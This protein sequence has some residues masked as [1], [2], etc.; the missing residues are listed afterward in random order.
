[1]FYHHMGYNC[2]QAVLCTFC[3]ELDLDENVAFR[4]S[5]GFGLWNGGSMECVVALSGMAIG[6]RR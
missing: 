4:I 2:A 3:E 6:D 5:E 1:M